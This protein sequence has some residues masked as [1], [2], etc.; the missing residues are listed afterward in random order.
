MTIHEMVNFLS[1]ELKE[2]MEISSIFPYD[3]KTPEDKRRFPR[4]MRDVALKQN[5]TYLISPEMH[6]F[7]LGNASAEQN[8]PHY[9]ILEDAKIIMFPN[10][11][12]NKTKGSQRLI[13]RKSQRD[14]GLVTYRQTQKGT[15]T[16]IIQEYR[17]NM[18]RN[19]AGRLL[20][21][22]QPREYY[23]R[24]VVSNINNRHYRY[25]KHYQYIENILKSITPMLAR[26][27]NAKLQVGS[28]D[29]LDGNQLAGYLTNNYTV[30]PTSYETF[31]QTWRTTE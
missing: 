13:G 21:G 3:Y 30:E 6:Y 26:Y 17:Q 19:Y 14:Y 18:T 16:Q 5:V 7:E 28:S 27:M 31:L 12:T 4:H 15:R 11:G 23:K 1:T 10:R 8:T 9:H 2:N 22:E 20:G 29:L 25:N 24:K